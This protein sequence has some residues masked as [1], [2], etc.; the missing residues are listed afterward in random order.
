MSALWKCAGVLVLLWAGCQKSPADSAGPVPG[1]L[2][3]IEGGSFEMGCDIC[4]ADEGPVHSVTL[5]SFVIDA[6]EVTVSQYAECVGEGECEAASFAADWSEADADR[7][8]TGVG[9][10]DAT[11]YCAWRGL[12]LPTE[13]RWEYAARG[14]EG[15]TYPWGEDS[16]DC[17]VAATRSCFGIE[18][19]G[20]HPEGAT[21]LGVHDLSGNAWEWVGDW[22]STDYY[23]VSETI[24]PQ[25]SQ[26]PG[27]RT[28]RGIELLSD[29]TVLRASNREYAIPDGRS[30]NVGFRC[31]GSP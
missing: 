15:H 10:N 26:S 12:V 29:P 24:D 28:V 30:A 31:A 11:V 27:L 6:Y 18:A 9:Y 8:V 2:V 17:T 23:A 3:E 13:A 14:A 22:Y 25:G 1:D 20:S 19:V 5:T 16:G 4:D 7:P 21:S